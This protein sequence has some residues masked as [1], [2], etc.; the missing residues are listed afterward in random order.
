VGINL[1][2]NKP[3]PEQVQKAVQQVLSEP[4]Y[5]QKAWQLQAEL[6]QHDAP[7]EAATLLERLADTQRPVV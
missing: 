7:A 2:T 6:T 3:T 4:S 5:R 1:K